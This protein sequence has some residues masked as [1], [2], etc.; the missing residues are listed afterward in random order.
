[1]LSSCFYKV[2]PKLTAA[3]WPV[4]G[5]QLV[6]EPQKGSVERKPELAFNRHDKVKWLYWYGSSVIRSGDF[7]HCLAHT[8]APTTWS[9]IKLLICDPGIGC[10]H[11]QPLLLPPCISSFPR[12]PKSPGVRSPVNL[13]EGQP[14]SCISHTPIRASLERPHGAACI[15]GN[16][17][18]NQGSNLGDLSRWLWN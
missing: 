18:R 17:I 10:H 13:T 11:P 2:K 16:S 15:E 8:S 6:S 5:Q 7:T 3:Q 4:R 12:E 14:A 1:M 9:F